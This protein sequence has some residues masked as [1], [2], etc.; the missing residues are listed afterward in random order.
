MT[1]AIGGW[2]EGSQNY[3]LM[4]RDQNKRKKFAASALSFIR[5]HNFDGLDLDWEYPGKRGGTAADKRNFI[6]L[7]AELRAAFQEEGFL[8]TAAIGAAKG[9]I[10]V[11]YDVPNMY[12]YLDF[13][14]GRRYIC[15]N[16][17]SYEK[18]YKQCSNVKL[19]IHQ[20][21]K[22]FHPHPYDN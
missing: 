10:D 4:A 14:N 9:T 13:V 7:V 6:S 12:K 5:R 17:N 11:S 3:S 15:E 8:L 21:S 1:L 16:D 22:L 2:N 18:V 19:F 20:E